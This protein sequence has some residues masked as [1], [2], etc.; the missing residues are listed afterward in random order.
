MSEPIKTQTHEPDFKILKT[1]FSDFE[2]VCKNLEKSP[3]ISYDIFKE[4]GKDLTNVGPAAMIQILEDNKIEINN[5]DTSKPEKITEDF[6]GFYMFY[7]NGKPEYCGISRNVLK[8]I[9]DHTKGGKQ[10]A[11]FAHR[12]LM[13]H[14]LENDINLSLLEKKEKL[15]DYKQDVLSYKFKLVKFY[16]PCKDTNNRHTMSTEHNE[17]VLMYLFEVFASVYFNTKHN[18]FSAH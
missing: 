3:L 13:S 16:T 11:T 8:R 15:E 17:E 6:A 14:L 10:T 4:N 5:Y 7:K 9:S 12:L 18:S 1:N 2:K